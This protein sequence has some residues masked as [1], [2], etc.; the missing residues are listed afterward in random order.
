[1][2]PSKETQTR[3]LNIRTD[4]VSAFF[5]LSSSM[6]PQSRAWVGQTRTQAGFIP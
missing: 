1:M 5:S 2:L 4:A 3:D 6:G